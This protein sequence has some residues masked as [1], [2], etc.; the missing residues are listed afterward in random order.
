MTELFINYMKKQLLLTISI[1][2][3][4][5]LL[6]FTTCSSDNSLSQVNYEE[7]KTIAFDYVETSKQ[8]LDH[9]GFDLELANKTI[10]QCSE[11]CYIF[12]LKYSVIGNKIGYIS[13]IKVENKIAEFTKQPTSI[14]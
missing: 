7:Y 14:N 4:F 9:K 8:K 1:I 10:N 6:I 2:C 11:D 13:E 12:Q 3:L 5:S